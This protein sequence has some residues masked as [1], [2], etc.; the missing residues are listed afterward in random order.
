MRIFLGQRALNTVVQFRPLQKAVGLLPLSFF[1]QRNGPFDLSVKDAVRPLDAPEPLHL[2]L[3]TRNKGH[4]TLDGTDPLAEG[5]SDDPFQ[6]FLVPLLPGLPGQD[7]VHGKG[8]PGN[9]GEARL[10]ERREHIKGRPDDIDLVPGP[11]VATEDTAG[12]DADQ[13]AEHRHDDEDFS[14]DA[15]G[16]FSG[17]VPA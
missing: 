13:K 5:V 2:F 6:L 3:S 16:L 10:H 1:C 11:A 7:V 15:H 9:D 12:N 14:L 17:A 8:Y 4:I